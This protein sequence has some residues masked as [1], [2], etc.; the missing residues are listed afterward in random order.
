MFI[1]LL[2]VTRKLERKMSSENERVCSECKFYT[3]EECD[4][5]NEGSER[6]DDSDACDGFENKSD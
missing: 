6:Y 1:N 2:C 4:G 3:G 5:L